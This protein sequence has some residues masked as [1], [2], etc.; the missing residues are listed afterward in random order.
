MIAM[1]YGRFYQE[2]LHFGA[3]NL[4]Q[5]SIDGILV[6]INSN[7]TSNGT[8]SQSGGNAPSAVGEAAIV[9]MRSRGWTVTV[10][11]GF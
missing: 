5:E 4:S 9:A 7:L 8:F 3:T 1:L 6:S 10:T 2:V 11:G